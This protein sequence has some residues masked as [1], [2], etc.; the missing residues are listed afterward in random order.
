MVGQEHVLIHVVGQLKVRNS[1]HSLVACRLFGEVWVSL[2]SR[3]RFSKEKFLWFLSSA[4][5][6]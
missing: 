3:R 5:F 2:A 6:V 1:T 4:D